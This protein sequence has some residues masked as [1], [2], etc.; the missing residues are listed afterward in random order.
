MRA[1]G[2]MKRLMGAVGAAVL[3]VALP[4]ATVA[5]AATTSSVSFAPLA[6]RLLPAV[7]NI[8]TSAT[9]K[10]VTPKIPGLPEG[11]PLEDFFNEFMGQQGG[12]KPQ[13]VQSLGSGF[14]I[15]A[16][17][18][19]VTNNHVIDG[20]DEIEVTFTDGTTLPATLVGADDKT[21]LA[22]LRVKPKKPLA[23]VK[24]GDSDASRVG[25]WVMA[26]GNP[27]GLGGSVS[28]G[29]I[30]ALNRD[31]HSGNYDDF[32][33]TDAAIN[34]GNSGGPLFNTAGDVIGVNSAIIS[35]SGESV[36]IGFAVPTS[37]VKPVVA[38]LLKHGETRRGWI[39]VRIQTVTPEIAESLDLG[40]PRGALV[41]GV[42]PGGPAEAAGV[43]TGDVVVSF[44]GQPVREM[45][46]LSRIVAETEIGI[47]APF[48]V[49]RDGKSVTLTAK[50]GRLETSQAEAATDDDEAG[51][52]KPAEEKKV[53]LLGLGLVAMDDEIRRDFELGDDAN[54][55]I[56]VSVDPDSAAAEKGM[57]IGDIVMQAAQKD[58]KAPADLEAAIKAEKK[59]GRSSVLLRLLTQGKTR[60]VALPIK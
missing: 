2:E 37:T 11:S 51:D 6:E 46:D 7:V 56:V 30:S 39:G 24:L 17:G 25:D 13:K 14:V 54:G 12:A 55:L 34:R 44:N 41:A 48:V 50:V 42:A 43:E 28:A 29:I 16:K 5:I 53:T 45:R 33:Q 59:A 60:F 23:F 57:R 47:S 20:A 52:E 26:I 4:V 49:H 3:M 18:I 58:M 40:K 36:G 22:V 10:R 27:F 35:P 31:I 15:D 38:Q 32:I 19:I 1:I 9:V 8:S 21:D